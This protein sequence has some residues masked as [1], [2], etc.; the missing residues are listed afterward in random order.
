LQIKR[1]TQHLN[2]AI[3]PTNQVGIEEKAMRIYADNAATTKMSERAKASML[4]FLTEIFGNASSLHSFGREA[5]SALAAARERVARCFNASER[6]IYFTSGGSEA[7]NQ[8]L[9][10]AAAIGARKN[11]KHIISTKFEHHAVLHAL[12]KLRKQGF[13][14]ELLNV[15]EDGIVNPRD[16]KK[17]IRPETAAVCVMYANNE[18]G[19]IQPIAEIGAICRA[20]NVLF[21][22]DA[23]Q[24][25]GRLKIDVAQDNIDLMAVSAHKFHGPK[26]VGALYCRKG[27]F[28]ESFIEGGAQERGKRAGTE[29]IAGIVSMAEALEESLEN[30]RTANERITQLREYIINGLSKIPRSRLNGHRE[31]RLPGTINMC[32]EGIEGEALLL[33]ADMAGIAASSGSACTSGSLDPSHVLLALGLPHEIAHGSLR[34]SLSD[35]NTFEEAEY[36]VKTLPQ[37]IEKLRDMSPVW[38]KICGK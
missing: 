32:F 28:L 19:T 2:S 21:I 1:L 23:V 6:E 31:K 27:V 14:I 11:K 34:L 17:A 10:T 16:V 29:N 37:I 4:P 38:E 35:Y 5:E 15:Y 25:A 26:G 22:T 18:I 8:A 30:A 20:S 12:D 24:A 36:M 33:M 3:I 9:Y 13:E 7:D